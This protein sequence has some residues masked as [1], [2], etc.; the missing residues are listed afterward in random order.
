[1]LGYICFKKSKKLIEGEQNKLF[2]SSNMAVK[3]R[4]HDTSLF[5]KTI[6]ESYLNLNKKGIVLLCRTS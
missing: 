1:M 6:K 5:E 2:K 4:T 3:L